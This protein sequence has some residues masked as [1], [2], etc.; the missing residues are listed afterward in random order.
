MLNVIQKSSLT[1]SQNQKAHSRPPFKERGP[2]RQKK[3]NKNPVCQSFLV[4]NMHV[5]ASSGT[6]LVNLETRLEKNSFSFSS[7]TPK[8]QRI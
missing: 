6:L 1:F 5:L 2:V 7:H 4:L 8:D 3:N